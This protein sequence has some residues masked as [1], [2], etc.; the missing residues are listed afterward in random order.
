MEHFY[1]HIK[2]NGWKDTA[3]AVTAAGTAAQ[4][5]WKEAFATYQVFSDYRN[6]TTEM[7]MFLAYIT[8]FTADQG[9]LNVIS[10]EEKLETVLPL[11]HL[12]GD[13]VTEITYSGV[14]DLRCTIHGVPW[15]IDHKTTGSYMQK[16]ID[17]LNRSFQFIGYS[18]L[19]REHYAEAE[20]SMASIAKCAS[21]KKKDGEW[22]KKSIDFARSVQ[23]YTEEDYD[24]FVTYVNEFAGRL[25]QCIYHG[26]WPKD[27]GACY[28]FG[29]CR[30]YTQC[31]SN[32]HDPVEGYMLN[33]EKSSNLLY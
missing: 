23:V 14:I 28:D 21:R 27:Y 30:Y 3:G 11:E 29:R 32:S 17:G 1:N 8:H 4:V 24:V 25:S 6:L 26:T 19:E 12:A 15:I 22:G 31:M 10:T 2:A 33:P 9:F 20:G 16:V 18:Y 13:L 5:F 7:E